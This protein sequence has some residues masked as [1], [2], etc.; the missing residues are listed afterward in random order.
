MNAEER[1]EVLV[2]ARL[3][4]AVAH[5]RW[6]S[7]ALTVL[8]AWRMSTGGAPPWTIGAILLGSIAAYY[9]IRVS[10]D[11]RLFDDVLSDRIST[12]ELDA[13]LRAFGKTSTDRPWRSRCRGARRL[14]TLLA[15]TVITQIAALSLAVWRA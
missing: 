3:L 8:A 13:A 7:A 11:A 4:R 14:V 5:I 10:L 15:A 1:A 12:Q 9:G 6:L 2:T